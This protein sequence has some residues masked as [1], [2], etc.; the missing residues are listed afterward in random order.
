[1]LYLSP[2]GQR[3]AALAAVCLLVAPLPVTAQTF[4]SVGNRAQG[5]GGAFVAVAD[6]ASMT[7]WNPAGV[8]NGGQLSALFERGQWTDP[9]MH[10]PAGPAVRNQDTG[11]AIALPG[12]GLSYYRVYLSNVRPIRPV[13]P[14]EGV[15]QAGLS[16]LALSQYG[17]TT[18]QSIGP[19][20]TIAT[21]LK[22]V[23]VGVADTVSVGGD[24]LDRAD[25]VNVPV[26]TKADIDMGALATL[27]P[28]RL[29]FTLKHLS[30][31]D[32]QTAGGPFVLQRQSRLGASFRSGSPAGGTG[33]TVAFD[34]DLNTTPT[35]FGDVRHVA[36]G[37]EGRFR[38]WMAVRG[39]YSA[40]TIGDARPSWSG[41]ASIGASGFFLDGML[42]F[43]RDES[44]D[45]WNI[46]VRLAL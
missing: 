28:L 44:K 20:L 1:M 21:T 9:S 31:P 36:V 19:G 5:M 13:G 32:F 23:R 22:L 11:F 34:S 18:G 2:A 29:G 12:F 43:G 14:G 30:E 3:V 39:G 7:W 6:D 42:T 46:G 10:P 25:S 41:G 45:G 33:L 8:A 15:A 24:A 27:G 26:E 17:F 38:R 16:K 40:N 35:L 4:E 37:A